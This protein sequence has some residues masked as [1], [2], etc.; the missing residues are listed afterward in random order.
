MYVTDIL[1]TLCVPLNDYFSILINTIQDIFCANVILE[2]F[3][4]F[5]IF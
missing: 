3:L 2:G 5:K 1:Y 4:T